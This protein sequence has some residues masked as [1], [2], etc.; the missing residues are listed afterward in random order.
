MQK[1]MKLISDKKLSLVDY[2]KQNENVFKHR[3]AIIDLAMFEDLVEE[4]YVKDGFVEK[5]DDISFVMH[6][7]TQ[8]NEDVININKLEFGEEADDEYDITYI[9]QGEFEYKPFPG[10]DKAYIT[11]DRAKYEAEMG[12]E[13]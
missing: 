3:R 11:R 5:V 13:M 8:Q 7:P 6:F 2:I 9:K 1:Y 12:A 4:C 10:F